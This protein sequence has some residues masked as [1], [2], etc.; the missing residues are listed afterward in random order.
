MF[1]LQVGGSCDNALAESI[2]DLYKTE[3]VWPRGL[4]KNIE[5]VE[6]VTLELVDWFNNKRLIEPIGNRPPA[7]LEHRCCEQ[8]ESRAEA[9]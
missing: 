8:L 9:T 1:M 3:L 5:E 4:W 2:V 6:Y 7:D